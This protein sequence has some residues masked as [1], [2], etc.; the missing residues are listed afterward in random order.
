MQRQGEIHDY[1]NTFFYIIYT[2]DI[3]LSVFSWKVSK[4]KMIQK[5]FFAQIMLRKVS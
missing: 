2:Q 3:F 5:F 1:S 4:K